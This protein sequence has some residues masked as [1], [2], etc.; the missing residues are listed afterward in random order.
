MSTTYSTCPHVQPTC[1]R[2]AEVG[3]ESTDCKAREKSVNCK[4]DHPSNSRSCPTGSTEK[5]I[6][7][8]KIKPHTQKLSVLFPHKRRFLE[9]AMGL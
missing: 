2:C 7:V 4:R 5:E 3:H 8:L 1:A 9:L 6:T